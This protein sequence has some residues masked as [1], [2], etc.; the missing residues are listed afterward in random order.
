MILPET[1]TLFAE[2]SSAVGES[3]FGD[4]EYADATGVDVPAHVEPLEATEVEVNRDV[5]INRYRVTV[6]L[7]ASIDGLSEVEWA[8]KRYAVQG[9]PRRFA[10]Y[11]GPRHYEFD[12][13]GVEG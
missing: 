9:E 13:R 4:P 3:I 7:E 12:M 11:R 2:E 6:E 10:G 8:G 5:R 1:V